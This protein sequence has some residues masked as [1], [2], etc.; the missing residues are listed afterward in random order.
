MAALDYIKGSQIHKNES[1]PQGAH[2]WLEIKIQLM[3]AGYWNYVGAAAIPWYKKYIN[4]CLTEVIKSATT[5]YLLI[6]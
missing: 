6:I 3:L 1:F 4:I 5:Y 2:W